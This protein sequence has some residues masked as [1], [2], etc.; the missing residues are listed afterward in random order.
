M[1]EYMLDIKALIRA[2]D[3]KES[4]EKYGMR[5]PPPMVKRV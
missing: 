4:A 5:I 2:K 3:E 1:H